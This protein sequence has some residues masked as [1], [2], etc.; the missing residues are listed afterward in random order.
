MDSE[1]FYFTFTYGEQEIEVVEQSLT[2]ENQ[3]QMG[4]ITITKVDA[5]NRKADHP[6]PGHL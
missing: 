6:V 4:Q 3:P 5:G 2:I 1:P